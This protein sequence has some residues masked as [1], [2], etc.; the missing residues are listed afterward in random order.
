MHQV[1]LKLLLLN[2]VSVTILISCI[3]YAPKPP[4]ITY[5]GI[6]PKMTPPGF[7]SVGPKGESVYKKWDDEDLRA[8]QCLSPLD[9]EI[10]QS[11]IESLRSRLLDDKD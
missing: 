5:W 8:G 6:Y 7:Y 11:Y 10:Q 4:E 2:L 1:S 3:S 9:F